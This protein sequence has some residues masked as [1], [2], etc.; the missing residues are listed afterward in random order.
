MTIS[1]ESAFKLLFIAILN[2]YLIPM[3][4]ISVLLKYLPKPKTSLNRSKQEIQYF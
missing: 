4:S 3:Y 1:V 2:A